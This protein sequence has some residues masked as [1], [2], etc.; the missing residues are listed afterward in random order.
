MAVVELPPC[1]S[2]ADTAWAGMH[3]LAPSGF[4]GVRSFA[5]AHFERGWGRRVSAE[6]MRWFRKTIRKIRLTNAEFRVLDTLCWHHGNAGCFPGQNMLADEIGCSTR[7]VREVLSQLRTKGA[8]QWKKSKSGHRTNDYIFPFEDPNRRPDQG[9]SVEREPAEFR[10]LDRRNPA[11]SSLKEENIKT[12]ARVERPSAG[13]Q[14]RPSGTMPDTWRSQSLDSRRSPFFDQDNVVELRPSKRQNLGQAGADAAL[15]SNSSPALIPY[16]AGWH[17]E[18]LRRLILIEPAQPPAATAFQKRNLG[19]DGMN[20]DKFVLE[21]QAQFGWPSIKAMDERAEERKP[22]YS[23]FGP[24]CL[25]DLLE[26]IRRG[27][28]VEAKWR[29]EFT[30]RGWPWLSQDLRRL[31]WLPKGGPQ[32]LDKFISEVRNSSVQCKGLKHGRPA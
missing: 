15:R 30:R 13:A 29:D 6:A 31:I 18:R 21:R 26:E 9:E 10:R 20:A 16:S 11:A 22:A 1:F 8:I 4:G 2:G 14:R 19:G 7:Q 27:S 5:G 12:S 3:A 23:E 17:L 24:C 28:G 32:A 25:T